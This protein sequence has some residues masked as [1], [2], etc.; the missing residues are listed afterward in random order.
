MPIASLDDFFSERAAHVIRVP[1]SQ[2]GIV[3]KPARAPWS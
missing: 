1:W 3:F 2:Q